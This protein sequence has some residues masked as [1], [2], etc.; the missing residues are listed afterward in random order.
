MFFCGLIV[1]VQGGLELC[2]P[3]R[4]GELGYI[5]TRA[6]AALKN[7]EVDKDML[8]P[9]EECLDSGLGIPF[10]FPTQ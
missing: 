10:C 1:Q 8:R 6:K 2:F 3:I 7:R 9:A 5:I 4:F